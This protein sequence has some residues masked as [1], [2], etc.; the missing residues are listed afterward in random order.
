[1]NGKHDAQD[2]V[3]HLT[4]FIQMYVLCPNCHL[5]ELKT[6]VGK[7]S[8]K[9]DCASC[10]HNGII[11][12]SHRCTLYMIKN[13]PGGGKGGKGKKSKKTEKAERRRQK[14]ARRK[15]AEQA[16]E[17][18]D[19]ADAGDDENQ[20]G[21]DNDGSGDEN[22]AESNAPERKSILD[23]D[24]SID[25]SKEAVNLR[26]A[27]E[28]ADMKGK[29]ISATVEAIVGSTGRELHQENPEVLL[30]LYMAQQDRSPTE[31][32]AELRRLELSR[33]LDS[34]Q[35]VHT[36]IKALFTEEDSPTDV[37]KA[38][39]KQAAT[40]AIFGKD[41]QTAT[42]LIGAFEDL[43]A[44]SL[45]SLLKIAPHIFK[46]LYDE[47]IVEDDVIVAWYDAPPES[48]WLVQREVGVT[49]RHSVS[50]VVDWLRDD[51]S[52][53]EEEEEEDDNE[54]APEEASAEVAEATETVDDAEEED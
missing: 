26:K 41:T 47:E 44:V 39:K 21:G 24:W 54:E 25:T 1:V 27:A 2:L 50:Q 42:I 10:G 46:A 4:K 23:D 31:V 49:V 32:M 6:K 19:D 16:A 17:A 9:I 37:L 14:V 11:K 22:A 8:I 20:D 48:D 38:I 43:V 33:S 12:N 3:V 51:E 29:D 40:L 18:G 5:P 7:K 13:P 53:E 28:M 35:K 34:P 30:R 52:S 36:L 15:K 45:P